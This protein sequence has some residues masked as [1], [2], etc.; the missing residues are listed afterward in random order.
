MEADYIV[1]TDSDN[2]KPGQPALTASLRG[3]IDAT[4]KVRVLEQ[5]LHSG[6]WGGPIIDSVTAAARLIAPFHDEDGNVAIEGLGGSKVADVEYPESDLRAEAGVLEGVELAG[7][8][9]LAS[10][11]WTQS[12]VAVIGFDATSVAQSGNSMSPETTF[13][14]SVRTVLGT[15][16]RK[17]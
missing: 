6:M 14:V 1:V 12:A 2:W 9:D 10:R 5:A 13:K 17:P 16:G 7:S 8:G 3:V 15:D 4:V 11:M